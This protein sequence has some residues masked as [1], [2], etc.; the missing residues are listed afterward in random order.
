MRS[1][2]TKCEGYAELGCTGKR[3]EVTLEEWGLVRVRRGKSFQEKRNHQLLKVKSHTTKYLF[4]KGYQG[5]NTIVCSL[6]SCD[7]ALCTLHP[8]AHLIATTN[9]KGVGKNFD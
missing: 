1:P 8:L 6:L 2:R 7:S 3:Q 4:I 5:Y 9:P